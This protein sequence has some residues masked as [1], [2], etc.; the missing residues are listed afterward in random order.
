M[1][2]EILIPIVT[3]ILGVIL[4]FVIGFGMGRRSAYQDVTA[5]LGTPKRKRFDPRP[6]W[7][8]KAKTLVNTQTLK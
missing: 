3:M 4:A 6:V 2:I 8:L 1:N 7:R 5:N